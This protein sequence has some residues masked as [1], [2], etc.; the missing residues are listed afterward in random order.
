MTDSVINL[1]D[2]IAS[3]KEQYGDEVPVDTVSD[4]V[5]SLVEGTAQQGEVQHIAHELRELLDYISS[6]RDELTGMRPKSLSAV[7][8]PRASDELS[9]VVEN[10]EAAASTVM[11]A[12]DALSEMAFSMEGDDADKLM[13]LSTDLFE[14]SSFQDITGQRIN[15]VSTTLDHLEGKLL[16]LAEAI[17]DDY[18]EDVE[19]EVFDEGGEVVN[20]DA[21]LHGPQLDGEGNSQAD[22]DAL[23]AS[24]D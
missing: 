16:S 8:I 4:V 12:A 22:I 19:E 10:T 13:K 18:V 1:E 14:A 2:R 24:F 6:A 9:A 21:L 20:Q 5:S 15:K 11:D 17:G 7:D 3:V 23:L